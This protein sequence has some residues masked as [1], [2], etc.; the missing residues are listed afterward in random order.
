[1][2]QP[3][4][5]LSSSL[6]SRSPARSSR[7]HR[8][9][10]NPATYPLHRRPLSFFSRVTLHYH[11]IFYHLGGESLGETSQQHLKISGFQLFGYQKFHGRSH[12]Q[13]ILAGHL[14]SDLHE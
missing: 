3:T 6:R 12:G 5:P 13:Y 14:G 9:V 10:R 7:P 8:P 4:G 2:T 1:M 11:H